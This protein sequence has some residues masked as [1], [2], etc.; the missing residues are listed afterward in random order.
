MSLK[1]SITELDTPKLSICI[2]TFNRC[3][4]IGATLESILAQIEDNIEIVIVDGASTD[5]TQQVVASYLLLHSK[6]HYFRE[7]TNSGV[8]C[9]YD[10]AVGY[11][12]GEYCWLMPDDDLMAKG[13]IPRVLGLIEKQNDLIVVNSECWNANFSRNLNTRMLNI[14]TD[15][16]FCAGDA[17]KVFVELSS[18]LSFIGSVIIKRSVWL[19]RDR[20][21]YFGSLFVHVG[22][23]FQHPP[24]EKV[25]VVADP[26]IIIRYG[27][28]MWTPRSFEIWYFKWPQLI[29]SFVDFSA[30]AKQK[31]VPREPWRR[32]ISLLKSRAMGDYSHTGYV[33]FL[34]SQAVSIDI[35]L[36]YIISVFPAKV[37]NLM[38]V[39]YYVLFKRS[40]LYTL[41]DLLRS[42]HSSLLGR[43]LASVFGIKVL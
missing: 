5:E 24:I 35:V 42:R 29:W 20:S 21:T 15:K 1:Q 11:A 38:C 33:K 8:D 41:F 18:C 23:I 14:Q 40:A 16:T 31:I 9:D 10:K 13:A 7:Q 22:V 3:K 37:A 17:E 26:Q 4:F 19:G 36:A 30:G 12:T 25:A 39:L 28:G 2:A 34:S 27:N 32:A 6:I 43:S